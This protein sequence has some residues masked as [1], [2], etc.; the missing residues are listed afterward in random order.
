MKQRDHEQFKNL[1][2]ALE[3]TNWIKV[4][5][6]VADVVGLVIESM[7]P[8]ARVGDLCLVH[9]EQD[10]AVKAEVVGFRGDRVF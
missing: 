2:A 6:R 5:G 10:G 4:T 9:T 8:N 3:R 1:T 7:G